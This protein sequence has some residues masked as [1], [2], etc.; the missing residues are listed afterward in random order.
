MTEIFGA[1]IHDSTD[2]LRSISEVN[3]FFI[4]LRGLLAELVID[5]EFCSIV[6]LY[7][8]CRESQLSSMLQNRKLPTKSRSIRLERKI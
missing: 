5:L 6:K 4:R 2:L 7:T 3:F 1:D 8:I